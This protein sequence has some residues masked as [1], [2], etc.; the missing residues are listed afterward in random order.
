LQSQQENTLHSLRDLTCQVLDVAPDDLSAEVPFTAY[1]L[2]SLS[3][4][5]LSHVLRPVIKISQI[6]LLA[7]MTLRDLELRLAES[8]R[9]DSSN[10]RDTTKDLIDD[11][12]RE[13]S[14]EMMHLVEKYTEGL[15]TRD[16]QESLPLSTSPTILLTGTTGSL[17]THM[18]ARLLLA[19]EYR[20]IYVLLRKDPDGTSAAD[21][22]QAAFSLR[23]LDVTLLRAAKLSIVEGDLLAPFLG[24]PVSLF[25]EL[26]DSVT[27]IA[28]LA[29]PI[30][31]GA[32]LSAYDSAIHGV[33][34]LV[35][36]ASTA[37][38]QVR[39]IFTSTAGIFR[40]LPSSGPAPETM[41]EDPII[42]IGSGYTESKW[43]A[44]KVL[45]IAGNHGAVLPTIVR[46][47]QLTGGVNGAWRT[48]EWVPSM[49]STSVA[50]GCLPDGS[51]DVSWISVDTAAAVMVDYLQ[52]SKLILHL[53]HPRPVPWSNAIRH[54]ASVLKL[55]L[56]SY[57]DWFTRL[58]QGL[59]STFDDERV[60]L[61]EPGLRLLEFFRL[62][63][64]ANE[65]RPD[66]MNK[67]MHEVVNA[68]GLSES[69]TLRN[70]VLPQISK[71]DVEKWIG[72]WKSARY[73]PDA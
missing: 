32:P 4:A 39:L 62:P 31:F 70:P 50:L 66:I 73:L 30:D 25:Y 68:N 38:H 52:S 44:E 3:A 13:K 58:D 9:T 29:W 43:V 33:R 17:G 11:A 1:G 36:V 61:L 6:Q 57:T 55:P 63:Y 47:G 8:G 21:R 2:D 54:F 48:A 18:L 41:I 26:T 14:Q 19:S 34:K 64:D 51:G 35:D 5:T 46:V 7:D 40:R 67:L 71:A 23:G 20:K 56:V 10:D 27:H 12:L 16:L 53:R 22:Q 42:A 49:I 28:H 37:R 65:P 60:H 45:Q 69:E 72:Y 15:S 24:L 59:L